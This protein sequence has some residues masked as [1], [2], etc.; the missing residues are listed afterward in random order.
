MGASRTKIH[1][2]W[3]EWHVMKRDVLAVFLYILKEDN[4]QRMKECWPIRCRIPIFVSRSIICLLFDDPFT[5][6]IINKLTKCHI[7][8]SSIFPENILKSPSVYIISYITIYDICPL[9]NTYVYVLP[10]HDTQAHI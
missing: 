2:V 9:F 10:N 6:L 5:G 4:R 3:I 8:S 1:L 7:H